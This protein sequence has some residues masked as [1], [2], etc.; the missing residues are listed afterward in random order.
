MAIALS[1]KQPWA[2][3]IVQGR[4]TIETR[5]W[6]T[7]FRG[8]FYIHA[9]KTIDKE[10]CKEFKINPN[11]LITGSIIGKAHLT[12]TKEYLTKKEFVQ[13]NN[14]HK[15][16][17]YEFNRPMFGF[18]LNHIKRIDPIPQKGALNFFKVNL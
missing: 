3:L 6:N 13:E 2:E 4:K 12:N 17:I 5:H 15:A 8:E 9:S 14:K 11:S 1:L 7:R 18:E 10:A 16:G